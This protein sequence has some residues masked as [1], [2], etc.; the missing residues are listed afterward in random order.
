MRRA[1]S[2]TLQP[3]NLDQ[4][5]KMQQQGKMSSDSLSGKGKNKICVSL[6]SFPLLVI[7][8]H[9]VSSPYFSVRILVSVCVILCFVCMPMSASVVLKE[10]ITMMIVTVNYIVCVYV[11]YFF[12]IWQC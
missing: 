3:H 12:S 6:P 9:P 5:F 7:T 4:A 1:G 8:I 10:V 11:L 2:L